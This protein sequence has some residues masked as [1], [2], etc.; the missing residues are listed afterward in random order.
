VNLEPANTYDNLLEL[1]DGEASLY[2]TLLPVLQGEKDAIIELNLGELG[3]AGK[4]KDEVLIKIRII[5]EKRQLII[6]DLA[7][8]LGCSPH[9][10]TVTKLSELVEE[11]YAARFKSLCS[12]LLPLAKTIRDINGA[13]KALI[14]H[15]A[16]L[17]RNSFAFLNNLITDNAVYYR[18]GRMQQNDQGGK[19]LCG[20]I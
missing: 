9:E 3:K 17:V 12:D 16:E 20:S 1:L 8:S 10:L 19:V 15:S 14:M 5:E 6:K 4:E 11:P 18:S 2:R 7:K 13:N